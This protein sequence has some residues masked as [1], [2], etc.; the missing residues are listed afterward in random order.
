MDDRDRIS[1]R[2]NARIVDA[3]KVRD[4]KDRT[5]IFVEGKRLVREA[6]RSA[7]EIEDAFVADDFRDDDLR[8]QLNV[9]L[10]SV[11]VV[12]RSVADSLAETANDQGIFLVA[13][14][15][16][17][18]RDRIEQKLLTVDIPIIVLLHEV[19]NPSNLGAVIRTAE[20]AGVVGLIVTR[21]SASAYSPKSLRASMGSAFRLPI[22]EG[23][24]FAEAIG[25]AKELRLIRTAAAA[26]MGASHYEVDWRVPR[27]L[28]FG[29]EAD[30]LSD[31]QLASVDNSVSIRMGP[32]V[33]SLNLAVAAGVLLFEA[34]R[35][36]GLERL[37]DLY[38]NSGLPRG[39]QH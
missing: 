12:S 18:G 14:R 19:N 33:E 9:R 8:R 30:G 34:R 7:I 5:R 4:G 26:S 24:N 2:E 25:W 15:P 32:E 17:G 36:Q 27:L 13:A 11:S 37:I 10:K 35:Q 6:L 31:E 22:W 23:V 1:S 20:G 3:R 28:V 39:E 29:S 38:S 16:L 21:N